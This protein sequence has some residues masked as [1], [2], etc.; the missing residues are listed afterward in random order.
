MTHIATVEEPQAHSKPVVNIIPVIMGAYIRTTFRTLCVV[1]LM[2]ADTIYGYIIS[3]K[4]KNN[5]LNYFQEA[6]EK[7]TII[8]TNNMLHSAYNIIGIH[9]P[10]CLIMPSK[11]SRFTQPTEIMDVT[12]KEA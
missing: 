7:Y 8:E 3:K 12:K 5:M 2:Q 10:D 11:K 9:S 1:A 4:Q 6:K